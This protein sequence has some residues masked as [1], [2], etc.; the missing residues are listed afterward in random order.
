[1]E[2]NVPSHLDSHLIVDNYCTHQRGKGKEWLGQRL[3][4]PLHLTPTYGPWIK[5]VE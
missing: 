1:M 3:R 4:F 2:G 5:Q